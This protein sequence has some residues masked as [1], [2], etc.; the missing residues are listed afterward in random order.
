MQRLII[1]LS[2]F[3]ALVA[4]LHQRGR[5]RDCPWSCDLTRLRCWREHSPVHPMRWDWSTWITERRPNPLILIA[6]SKHLP[7][8]GARNKSL[9]SSQFERKKNKR[10]HFSTHDQSWLPPPELSMILKCILKYPEN[11]VRVFSPLSYLWPGAM[12][13]Q[14]SN[15]SR[16]SRSA[17]NLRWC[18]I[19]WN[20]TK[21]F[22]F[23][24]HCEER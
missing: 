6:S 21:L 24:L 3:W 15:A 22:F 19:T 13:T 7:A 8:S 23:K 18:M 14:R 1:T 11:D 17:G 9:S 4:F 16:M 12:V 20:K 5:W 2:R 10:M